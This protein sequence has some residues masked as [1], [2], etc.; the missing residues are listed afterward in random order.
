MEIMLKNNCMSYLVVT[1]KV[2]GWIKFSFIYNKMVLT[3][4]MTLIKFI[5]VFRNPDWG[6]MSPGYPQSLQKMLG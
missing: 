6:V 3:L 2:F 1:L 4:N 5:L